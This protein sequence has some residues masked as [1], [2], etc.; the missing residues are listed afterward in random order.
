M[1]ALVRYGTPE[2]RAEWLVPLLEGKIRPVSMTE[3]D[4]ASLDAT[5][6]RCPLWQV[7]AITTSSTVVRGG[8]PALAIRNKIAIV[9]GRSNP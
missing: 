4:V 9:M 7:T 6:I 3:P 8:P 1:E 5:N 2:Q